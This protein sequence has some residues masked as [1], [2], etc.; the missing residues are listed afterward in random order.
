MGRANMGK[1][2]E[3]GSDDRIARLEARL[4]A[5][6]EVVDEQ[7]MTIAGL[8]QRLA[9]GSRRA[10]ADPGADA[11]PAPVTEDESPPGL[12]RRRLLLGGAGAAAAGA[13]AL[14]ASAPPAAAATGDPFVLGSDNN[15]ATKT[16]LLISSDGAGAPGLRIGHTGTG[17]AFVASNHPADRVGV[18]GDSNHGT[19]VLGS[20]DDGL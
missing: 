2:E 11:S 5:V 14:V 9:T 6:L 12:G 10:S 17:D 16:T 7:A 19:G 8:E 13:V 3:R 15:V 1:L 20:S 4:D 18:H